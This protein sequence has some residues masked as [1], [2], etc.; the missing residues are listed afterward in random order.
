ML[1]GIG[2]PTISRVI[3]INDFSKYFVQKKKE[4]NQQKIMEHFGDL[5]Q[6]RIVQKNQNY[7]NC[8]A[9]MVQEIQ[10]DVIQNL[11]N[12][13]Q[14]FIQT[15]LQ[16][17]YGDDQIKVEV[18]YQGQKEKQSIQ[19]DNGVQFVIATD[20]KTVGLEMI[21]NVVRQFYIENSRSLNEQLINLKNLELFKLVYP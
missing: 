9:N 15:E 4:Q 11:D 3:R 1:H 18:N 12:I 5:Y 17:I 21:S 2:R 20:G 19:L 8:M 6:N 14:N 10:K 16:K 7:L 13:V